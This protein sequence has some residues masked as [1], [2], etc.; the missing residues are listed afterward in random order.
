MRLCNAQYTSNVFFTY[1]PTAEVNTQKNAS[2]QICYC[3]VVSLATMNRFGVRSA[4]MPPGKS[5]R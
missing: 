2:L 5:S 3:D 1:S 4:K